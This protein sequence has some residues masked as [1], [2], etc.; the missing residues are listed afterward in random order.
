MLAVTARS[1]SPLVILVSTGLAFSSHASM[2]TA[3]HTTPTDIA[4]SLF[5]RPPSALSYSEQQ[6]CHLQSATVRRES[7]DPGWP[8]ERIAQAGQGTTLIRGREIP[9]CP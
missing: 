8:W 4:K 5:I 2:L 9:T 1:K 3:R 6:V 7:H